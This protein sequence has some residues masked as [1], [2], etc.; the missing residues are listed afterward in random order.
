MSLFNKIK[1]FVWSKHFLKHLGMI[2]LS[3]VIIVGGTIYYLDFSTNH[4]EKIAVPKLTGKNINS[5]KASLEELGLQFEVLD[6]VY[7]PNRPVG[8]ILSQDPGPTDSTD[9]YVK[10]GRIIRLRISKKTRL[11]EVP[12]LIDK[13]ERFAISV[14]KNRG[15]KYTITYKATSESDG[16]VLEQKMNG[17]TIVEGR[18]IPIGS[19]ISLVVGR[20]QAS[21][22]V[23]IPD[24]KGLS[25]SEARVRISGIGS[26]SLFE[27]YQNCLNA[28]DSSNARVVSQS[29]EFI[30]GSLSSSSTTITIQLE[31]N[32]PQ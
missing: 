18:K 29:P 14:L 24:L 7:A 12:S 5:I 21:A 30:E 15:L 6:S 1:S 22:P 11:V 23:Q 32:L 10:E 25:S 16:A 19:T 27:V 2:V 20:N 9:V 13:S 4:G 3:Y 17:S 8:T 31:K 28:A 26:L